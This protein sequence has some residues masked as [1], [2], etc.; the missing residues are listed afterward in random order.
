MGRLKHLQQTLPQNMKDNADYPN[1]QFV[2][3]NY[4]GEKETE[5]WVKDTFKSDIATGRLKYISYPAAATFKMAHAK[6]MATRHSDGDIVC[7]M[8]ADQFSGPGFA[9]LIA[10][11]FRQAEQRRRHIYMRHSPIEVA[12]DGNEHASSLGKIAMLHTDFDYFR[13][14][15]ENLKGWGGDDT[16]MNARM[17]LHRMSNAPIPLSMAKGIEHSDELRTSMMDDESKTASGEHLAAKQKEGG[18]LRSVAGKA[19][20]LAYRMVTSALAGTN[21]PEGFGAG[22]VFIN[23]SQTA[24]TPPTNARATISAA[25]P[26]PNQPQIQGNQP[27]RM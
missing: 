9:R 17:L 23:F 15:N 20:R 4:G 8:D 13:G 11:S 10:D 25:I 1:A 27:R 24:T 18:G 3:L 7:N 6:N 21:N 2:V 5:Q 22:E 12:R 26:P 16:D 19:Q 14:Y